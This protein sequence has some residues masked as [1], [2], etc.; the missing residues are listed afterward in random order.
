[1]AQPSHSWEFIQEQKKKIHKKDLLG[2][3]HSKIIHN[4]QTPEIKVYQLVIGYA[5]IYKYIMGIV[6]RNKEK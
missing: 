1:M 3:V 2:N 6:L 4:S 5:N